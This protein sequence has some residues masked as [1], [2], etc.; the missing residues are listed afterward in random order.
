MNSQLRVVRVTLYMK[1]DCHLCED[2]RGALERLQTRYPHRL[3]TI[4]ITTQPELVTRYGERIPVLLIEGREFGAPLPPRLLER[5][6][7]EA[8]NHPAANRHA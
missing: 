3:D 1:A 7:R 8:A 4:D 2:V 5:A 6:L